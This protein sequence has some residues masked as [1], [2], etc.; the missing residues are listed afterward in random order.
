MAMKDALVREARPVEVTASPIVEGST[1]VPDHPLNKR[2]ISGY[3]FWGILGAFRVLVRASYP[4]PLVDDGA[5]RDA[6]HL[7]QADRR[8]RTGLDRV[9]HHVLSVAVPQARRLRGG[10]DDEAGGRLP[11]L[12]RLRPLCRNPGVPSVLRQELH[13]VP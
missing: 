13:P 6:P 11:G 12:G 4:D 3:V 2:E 7:V 5:A 1:A 9:P 10:A 8:R